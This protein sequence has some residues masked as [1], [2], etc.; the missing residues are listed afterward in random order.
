MFAAD[1]RGGGGGGRSQ[2]S[3]Q[4]ITW[5]GPVFC[6][7]WRNVMESFKLLSLTVCVSNHPRALFSS[8]TPAVDLCISLTDPSVRY[9]NNQH[10]FE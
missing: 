8:P 6:S 10:G 2:L 5:L 3:T 7:V 9:L 4:Y 1:Y